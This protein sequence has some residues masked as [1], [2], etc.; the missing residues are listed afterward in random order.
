MC[1]DFIINGTS[2]CCASGEFLPATQLSLKTPCEAE[3]ISLTA[4]AEIFIDDWSQVGIET[5]PYGNIT[6]CYIMSGVSIDTSW[7]EYVCPSSKET[8]KPYLL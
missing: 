4:E 8:S 2:H 6:K 3:G 1:I 5:Y 7:E